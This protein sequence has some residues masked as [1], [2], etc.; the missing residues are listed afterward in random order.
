MKGAKGTELVVSLED[1]AGALGEITSS[2]K[3]AGLN[4]RAVS[5]WIQ[6]GKAVIRLVASDSQKAKEVLS[7]QFE[8][9]EA[10]VVVVE[11]PNE[12]G[13]LDNLSAALKGAGISMSHIY[14]STS[15][16]SQPATLVFASDNND[17]AVESISA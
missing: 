12:I 17:K 16:E 10:E 11:M 14:G 13:Q 3:E 4:I 7:S 2:L 8:V 9:R 15:A 5:G 6:E 1:K